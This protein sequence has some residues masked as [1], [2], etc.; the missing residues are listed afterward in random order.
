VTNEAF[1]ASALVG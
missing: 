1:V